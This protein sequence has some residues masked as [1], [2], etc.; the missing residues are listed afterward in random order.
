MNR[1][2]MCAGVVAVMM[3]ITLIACN[4]PPAANPWRDDALT[5]DTWSTPTQDGILASG[6]APVVRQRNTPQIE[7]PLAVDGVPHY[8]LWFEDEFED[9][10]DGDAKSAWTYADYLAMFFSAG[11]FGLNT[12]CSPVSAIVVPPGASLVSDGV[13]GKFHDAE[14]GKLPNPTATTGD[15][16]PGQSPPANDPAQETAPAPQADGQPSTPVAA[17][18]R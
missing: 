8:S 7:T 15:F 18:S 11:R 6:H 10:G 14:F 1:T 2:C 16:Y 3:A 5:H 12:F 17:S 4:Q 13:V 9:K